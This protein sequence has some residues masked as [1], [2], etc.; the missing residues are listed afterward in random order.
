MEKMKDKPLFYI[1]KISLFAALEFVLAF[2][3]AGYLIPYGSTTIMYIPVIA[4]AYLYGKGAGALIGAVFGITSIWKAS[5]AGVSDFDALFSPFFSGNVLGSL[6]TALGSRIL[7]GF[8]AGLIFSAAKNVKINEYIKVITI[9]V[10]SQILHACLVLMP[11]HLFFPEYA[12]DNVSIKNTLI[13]V[14]ELIQV[15]LISMVMAAVVY[16][17]RNKRIAEIEKILDEGR[18]SYYTKRLKIEGA[19]FV[20]FLFFIILAL[21]YHLHDMTLIV[22]DAN[23]ITLPNQARIMFINL[24]VQFLAG[25]AAISHIIGIFITSYRVYSV[26]HINNA[27]KDLMTGLYS[28]STAVDYGAT[29]TAN[30]KNFPDTYFIIFDIDNFKSINDTYGH[31]MGDKVI[32]NT[33][34]F[35]EKH[36]GSTGL[37][38]RFGG[39]EFAVFVTRSLSRKDIE[40]KIKLFMS[41]TASINLGD[42]HEVT[43]SIGIVHIDKERKFD[44]VYKKADEM[45]YLVKTSGRNGY[46]F[47][48]KM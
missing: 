16:V 10:I 31:L 22:I 33:A 34:R 19:F 30:K 44:E 36:F 7:F 23:N 26:Y 48:E 5:M 1:E 35:L 3:G 17:S 45:L 28:K 27:D 2:S 42:N 14:N 15:I 11:M 13:S 37:A 43:C 9:S 8:T 46:K 41:D 40:E 18:Q 29:V 12:A 4:A 21:M 20:S 25:V 39:D 6:Y 32:I 24:Q 38:A 47:Y